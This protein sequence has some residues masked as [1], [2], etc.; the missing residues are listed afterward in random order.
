MT[1]RFERLDRR[2]LGLTFA[3][4]A[5]LGLAADLLGV[6]TDVFIAPWR[7][8]GADAGDAVH[9][10]A[11]VVALIGASQMVRG[12]SSGGRLVGLSLATN[13]AASLVWD[14]RHLADPL[15]IMVIGGWAAMLYLVSR[16]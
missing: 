5:L 7:L 9:T 16:P 2:R 15:T 12:V 3:G 13:I 6:T 8:A 1:S 14:W 10:G 11:S 4:L